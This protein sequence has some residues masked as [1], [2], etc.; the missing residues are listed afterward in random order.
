ME[1]GR[2]GLTRINHQHRY[3]NNIH[4]SNHNRN[5]HFRRGTS[6][7]HKIDKKIK[8]IL[9]RLFVLL[10]YVA[11]MVVGVLLGSILYLLLIRTPY[12]L[13]QGT[14]FYLNLL[15]YLKKIVL[16]FAQISEFQIIH[17]Q[18]EHLILKTSSNYI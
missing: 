3:H 16:L 1:Y 8:R 4:H 5:N 14:L 10:M 6:R 11:P 18:S 2:N 13:H 17:C 9:R 15:L 12:S 7:M